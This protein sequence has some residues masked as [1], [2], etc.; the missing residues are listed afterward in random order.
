MLTHR[1]ARIIGSGLLV[2]L[3]MAVL[4]ASAQPHPPMQVVQRWRIGGAGGW[5][6]PIGRVYPVAAAFGAAAAA[7]AD[8]PR[9]RP[10]PVPD[11]FTMLVMGTH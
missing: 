6:E 2:G 5:L 10:V 9:P 8:Q 4:T 7:A 1:A 11:S 3:A